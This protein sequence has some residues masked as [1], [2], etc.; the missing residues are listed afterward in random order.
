MLQR[1]ENLRRQQQQGNNRNNQ[2][3]QHFDARDVNSSIAPSFPYHQ[4][5]GEPANKM[6]RL[7]TFSGGARVEN[8]GEPLGALTSTLKGPRKASRWGQQGEIDQ[9]PEV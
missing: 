2:G 5:E 4:G 9:S 8:D 6:A 7:N 3:N 1:R